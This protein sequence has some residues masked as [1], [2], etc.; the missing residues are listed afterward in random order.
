[1][2]TGVGALPQH[3]TVD[4][5]KVKT[6]TGF[7]YIPRKKPAHGMV[8]GYRFEVSKD[9][10]TWQKAAEGEF[11]NLAA[12]PIE[13]TVKFPKTE[14]RYFKFV[15]THVLAGDHAAVAEIGVIE[16]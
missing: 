6:L 9:N 11:G 7:T 14:A 4:M 15:A 10:K 12:N 8:D 5:G 13:Q 1:M 16:E 3:L 2:R